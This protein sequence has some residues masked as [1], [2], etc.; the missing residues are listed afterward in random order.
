[1]AENWNPIQENF[2]LM[3]RDDQLELVEH[4]DNKVESLGEML[5]G[6]RATKDDFECF[7]KGLDDSA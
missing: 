2:S 5:F 4:F 7:A 1:M 3:S 6:D